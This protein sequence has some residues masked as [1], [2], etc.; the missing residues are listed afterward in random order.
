MKTIAQQLNITDFPFEIK[1]D[2]GN[3][4][5]VESKDGHWSR[6]EHDSE[7]K[8]I[9]YQNSYNYWAKWERS[10]K[11]EIYYQDSYG[12]WSKSQYDENGR[13]I[14]S[15]TSEGEIIDNRPNK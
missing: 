3:L 13:E 4:I 5:Y 2:R 7:G 11:S 15:E 14:Y 9:Y 12:F 6:W 10:D 8:E 1:D